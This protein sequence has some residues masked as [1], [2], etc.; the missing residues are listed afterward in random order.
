MNE[1]D[2]EKQ[3]AHWRAS[4]GEDWQT[5]QLL[6]ENG[7]V[8]HGLFF[9]HL[10]LEKMLKAHVTRAT[11][12]VAPKLHSLIRLAQLSTVGLSADQL[13]FLSAFDEFNIAGR[14]P[15]YVAAPPSQARAVELMSR[16]KELL[17]WLTK[18]L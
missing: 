13:D 12:D 3:V 10:A 2:I 6:V 15:E 9:A 11:R 18:Q 7:R 1:A 17:T 5:A 8:R 14:Y 16:A 4:A